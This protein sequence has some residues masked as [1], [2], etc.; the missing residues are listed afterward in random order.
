[1]TQDHKKVGKDPESVAAKRAYKTAEDRLIED[2][3]TKS[4]GII[5]TLNKTADAKL[6]SKITHQLVVVDEAAHA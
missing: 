3:L 6:Q 2:T 5:T 1:M 4:V